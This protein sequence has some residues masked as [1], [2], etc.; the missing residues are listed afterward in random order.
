MNYYFGGAFGSG[1]LHFASLTLHGFLQQGFLSF[2]IG[3]P[4]L[5]FIGQFFTASWS[6]AHFFA[7]SGLHFFSAIAGQDFFPS[8]HSFLTGA[9][10]AGAFAFAVFVCPVSEHLVSVEDFACLSHPAKINIAIARR[11]TEINKLFLII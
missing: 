3:Q 8:L 5:S 11:E 7:I 2:I 6:A 1:A 9:L 4:F 10:Q